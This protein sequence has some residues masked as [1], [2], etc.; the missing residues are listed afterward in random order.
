MAN[1]M[2]DY[3]QYLNEISHADDLM[4]ARRLCSKFLRMTDSGVAGAQVFRTPEDL[5]SSLIRGSVQNMDNAERL[6]A[7]LTGI[8]CSD[9]IVAVIA[10]ND[11]KTQLTEMEHQLLQMTDTWVITH[12]SHI[13]CLTSS[14]KDS[15]SDPTFRTLLRRCKFSA[16]LSRPFSSITGVKNAY[17]EAL[18]TLKTLRILRKNQVS[19]GYDDFLM[20]RLLD[21]MRDDIDL[22]VFCLPDIRELQIYDQ[23]HDSELC[24]TLLCYL[25]HAKNVTNTAADLNVHR[26][27]VHYRINK[28]TEILKNLDFSNDYI[29][30]LLML[31]LYIAEYLYYREMRLQAQA[32]L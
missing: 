7:D 2:I 26:N 19:A 8:C 17:D 11:T 5:L 24:R 23:T 13:I 28:C 29:A 18:S 25:E 20:I 14:P 9:F 31:S 12:Q 21:S 27:T 10:A 4:E 6:W 1:H 15:V 16:G 30:F 22:N 32:I 3:R